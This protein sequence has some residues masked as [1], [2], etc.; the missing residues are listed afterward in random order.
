MC[1]SVFVCFPRQLST[2]RVAE[3]DETP[4]TGSAADDQAHGQH[5]SVRHLPAQPAHKEESQ[6]D[7]HPTQAVHQ[8][9]SQLTEAEVALCHRSHHGLGDFRKISQG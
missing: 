8:A 1:L 6:D 2:S 5:C 9:V 4:D 7:L 3:E